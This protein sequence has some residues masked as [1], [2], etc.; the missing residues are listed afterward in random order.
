MID[1]FKLSAPAALP[2]LNYVKFSDSKQNYPVTVRV[3]EINYVTV[4]GDRAHNFCIYDSHFQLRK[5]RV[6]PCKYCDI[7]VLILGQGTPELFAPLL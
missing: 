7:T 3:T 6:P 4:S 2:E 5:I 1:W